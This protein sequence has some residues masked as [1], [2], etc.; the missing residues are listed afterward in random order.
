MVTRYVI[1][2]ILLLLLCVPQGLGNDPQEILTELQ[3]R[4][5][6]LSDLAVDF[7]QEVH[8]GVFAAVERTSGKMFLGSGDRFRVQ[9][10]EQT[11]VSDGKMLWVYSKENKQVTIDK[12]AK[13]RDIV[14]PSDYLFTFRES[15]TSNL[16]PDTAISKVECITIQLVCEEKDE[17]IQQMTL[18]IGREDLLT[19]RASY[20]DING[21]NIIIDFS[22]LKIDRGLPDDVFF[23]ETP[24]GVEEVRLP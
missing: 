12:V 4:Y 9:T 8:S 2:S 22:N 10:D 14:R 16:L 7:V 15:Y 19:H 23:F 5:D 11:I 13:S 17:F 1:S 20:V 6:K 18:Y 3:E 21:N 24:E